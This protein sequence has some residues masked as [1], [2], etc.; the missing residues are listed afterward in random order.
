MLE[1]LPPELSAALVGAGLGMINLWSRLGERAFMH[2]VSLMISAFG[3]AFLSG[4]AAGELCGFGPATVGAIAW[5]VGNVVLSVVD[6]ALMIIT[7]IPFI[8]RQLAALLPGK[9]SS[10]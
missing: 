6:S 5:M 8:K 2:K 4:Y 10:E 9:G 7:D 3:G 1:K